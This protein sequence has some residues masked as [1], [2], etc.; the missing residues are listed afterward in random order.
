MKTS[1]VL[2]NTLFTI[3]EYFNSC[4]T[5]TDFPADS[6]TS[7]QPCK[8]YGCPYLLMCPYHLR[9]NNQYNSS[10]ILPSL[11]VTTY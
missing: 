2:N 5:I 1:K 10:V 7:P 3:F 11:S 8:Y 9:I 4:L 6:P